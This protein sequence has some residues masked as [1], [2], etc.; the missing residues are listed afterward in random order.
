M[1]LRPRLRWRAIMQPIYLSFRDIQT[2]TPTMMTA[3][4]RIG[5]MPTP[6]LFAPVEVSSQGVAVAQD[7]CGA[8]SIMALLSRNYRSGGAISC[9]TSR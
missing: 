7:V 6:T 3:M 2:A 1:A 4:M 5:R 9:E 8:S